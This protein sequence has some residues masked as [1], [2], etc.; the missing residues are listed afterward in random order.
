MRWAAL[1]SARVD[2]VIAWS[3]SFPPDLDLAQYR[4]RFGHVPLDYV[5]GDADEFFDEAAVQA[6]CDRLRDAG[7]AFTFTSFPGRHTI[8][9]ETLLRIAVRG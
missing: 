7:V 5:S 3:G 6:Q 2:R 8:D 4:D 9:R 1:G